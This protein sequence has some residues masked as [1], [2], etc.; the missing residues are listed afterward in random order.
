MLGKAGVQI[1]VV[2]EI[3]EGIKKTINRDNPMEKIFN[4]IG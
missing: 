1:Q 3:K 2:K 4:K